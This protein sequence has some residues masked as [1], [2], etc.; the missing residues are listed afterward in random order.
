[1]LHWTADEPIFW[2]LIKE[3]VQRL[4]HVRV[5]RNLILV[6]FFSFHKVLFLGC[7]LRVS[8]QRMQ[9]P[10]KYESITYQALIDL[11]GLPLIRKINMQQKHIRLSPLMIQVFQ[12]SENSDYSLKGGIHLSKTNT[13]AV[14]L[15]SESIGFLGANLE[16]Y[17]RIRENFWSTKNV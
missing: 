1:M 5:L 16:T 3:T 4:S 10:E 17:F 11:P 13:H 6:I 15:E 12:F 7:Q 14:H 9:P 2:N 8:H